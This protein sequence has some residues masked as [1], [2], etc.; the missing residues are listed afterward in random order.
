M[1]GPYGKEKGKKHF[2]FL[3]LIYPA[4]VHCDLFQVWR[5]DVL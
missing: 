5:T 2:G 4:L 3:S 1:S